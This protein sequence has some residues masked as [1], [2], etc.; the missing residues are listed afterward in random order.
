MNVSEILNNLPDDLKSHRTRLL[1]KARETGILKEPVSELGN[2]QW[3]AQEL[4]I[5]RLY[6]T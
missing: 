4:N 3:L 2:D 1:A 5:N 6:F